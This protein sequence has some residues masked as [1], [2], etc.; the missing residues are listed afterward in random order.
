MTGTLEVLD[1]TDSA[2]V[3]EYE[4]A[5]HDAFVRVTSNRLVHQLW[6]WD[7]EN[8]RLATRIPY[9][10]QVVCVWR[11]GDG[12]LHTAIAFNT[13]MREFQSSYFGFGP[14]GDTAGCFEV[15]TFFST[16]PRSIAWLTTLWRECLDLLSS[17]HLKVGYATTAR[18][19]MRLYRIGGW[20]VLEEKEIEGEMRYF[21]T[22][23]NN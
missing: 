5:F 23:R 17:M 2:Q 14:A 12:A 18:R 6:A 10:D 3:L 15:L 7:Y 4:T 11:N 20:R 22:H 13:A 19:P 1:T 8:R 21:L 16:G 9:S